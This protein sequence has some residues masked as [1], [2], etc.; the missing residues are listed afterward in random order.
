MSEIELRNRVQNLIATADTDF[1]EKVLSLNETSQDE[2]SEA[3]KQLVRER[4]A[5]YGSDFS[6]HTK[7]SDLKKKIKF[8]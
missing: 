4:I 1:L 2:I 3:D 6:K 5:K 7:L 8:A